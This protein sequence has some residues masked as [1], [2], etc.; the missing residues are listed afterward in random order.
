MNENKT[1]TFING[2]PDPE[3]PS[4]P[5]TCP[6]SELLGKRAVQMSDEEVEAHIVKMRTAREQPQVLRA[7][8][9]GKVKKTKSPA[10]PP[11]LAD[12]GF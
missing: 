1:D 2:Q 12:L 11:N 9:A 8:L 7:L 6:I 5:E 4:S 3:W 10:K